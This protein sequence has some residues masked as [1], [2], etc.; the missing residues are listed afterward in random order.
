MKIEGEHDGD[1]GG[2][3]IMVWAIAFRSVPVT[4][5]DAGED[6]PSDTITRFFFCFL[7]NVHTPS[8]LVLVR[9]SV[10]H[11]WPANVA[12]RAIFSI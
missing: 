11:S 10:Q 12:V 3:N 7:I 5:F 9:N 8:A 4:V 1:F 6:R 2:W